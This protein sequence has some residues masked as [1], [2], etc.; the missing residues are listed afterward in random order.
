MIAERREIAE[1]ARFDMEAERH[2]MDMARQKQMHEMTTM[3]MTI[4]R[5]IAQRNI[6]VGG[7]T[8]EDTG[9]QHEQHHEDTGFG[10]NG[11]NAAPS[12]MEF[13][14]NGAPSGFGATQT[15]EEV[16]TLYSDQVPDCSNV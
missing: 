10:A 4:N 11:A 7:S 12:G 3:L 9:L 14:A 2:R 8:Q 15:V 16:D 1:K 13:G 5:Q 6:A